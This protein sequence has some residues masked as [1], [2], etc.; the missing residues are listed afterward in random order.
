MVVHN[1]NLST[2]RLRQEAEDFKSSLGYNS[3]FKANLGCLQ[4]EIED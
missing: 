1:C 4:S 3:E 2:R